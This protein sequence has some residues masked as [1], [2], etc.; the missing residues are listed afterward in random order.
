MN[1]R[2]H[3]ADRIDG[4]L[5][6]VRGLR[7]RLD[8]LVAIAGTVKA[9]LDGGGTIYTAGNGGSAAE[10]L[11]LA[12][13]L[14]G[15]YRT[16]RPPRRAVCLCADPTALTCIANDFGFEAVFERQCEALTG[17]GDLLIVFSTSGRSPNLV[18]ALRAAKSKGCATAGF[19]GRDG[20]DCLA[21][22]DRAVVVPS[23]DAAHIQEAHQVAMHLLCE[24]VE[25]GAA[26]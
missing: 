11:H 18:R 9:T 22:C 12:E 15:R 23:T 24:A 8:D 17:R 25:A 1:L 3:F 16:S 26:P 13:E 19:L 14:I 5:E 21:L 2:D 20:G 7:H 10:A 6:A 4:S